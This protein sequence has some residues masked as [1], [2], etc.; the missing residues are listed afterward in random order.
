MTKV[1][2]G[3]GKLNDALSSQEEILRTIAE[4]ELHPVIDRILAFVETR[5]AY[6]YYATGHIFG[7]M[8]IRGVEVSV[9][10]L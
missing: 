8:V 2:R 10:E 1:N 6:Q 9:M 4:N 5:Q 7:K 3:K